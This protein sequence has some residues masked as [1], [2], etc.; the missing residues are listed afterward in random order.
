MRKF[1]HLILSGI[2]YL[3]FTPILHA[4]NGYEISFTIPELPDTGMVLAYYYSES[5][6]TKDTARSDK[7]GRFVFKGDKKLDRGVYIVVLE[8]NK[9]K[10]FDFVIDRSQNFRVETSTTNF[11]KFLKTNDPDNHLFADNLLF[12]VEM[13]KKANPFVEIINDT[14]AGESEKMEARN[15]ISAINQRVTL[16]QDSLIQVNPNALVT[17]MLK[18]RKNIEVPEPPMNSDGKIDSSF[19]YK[20]FKKH[21]WDNMDLMDDGLI[22]LP[23]PLYQNKIED[24][25]SRLV[26]PLP[27]SVNKEIDQLA[28]L[29]KSNRETYKFFI[30]TLTTKYWSPDVMGLDAVFVHLY[31]R[32]YAS[33]EMDYWA[34]GQ[35]KNNLK[36]QATRIRL[37]MIGMTAP[38]LI[39]Q[40]IA[41]KPVSMYDLKNN[42]TI[43]Y[44]Y[45]PD[46]GHCK[47]ETPVLANF[48]KNTKVD[49]QVYAVS[50]D[51]SLVKMKN[52]IKEMGLESWVN[53]NGPRTYVGH[54]QSLY[55]AMSTPTLY[56]LDEKKKIIAKKIP[57]AQ[58]DDFFRNYINSKK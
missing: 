18:A 50:V 46:C 26:L 6:Y 14:T 16:Y 40:D 58:L 53:V 52:Y 17:K 43:L 19:Q 23:F 47:T 4:Q 25:F 8:A 31:D 54:Y 39:M 33:G 7:D 32:Y 48:K 22:R 15:Q 38:N 45:D 20:Y 12:T 36:E 44:F 35:L 24:Y 1:Y 5:T 27:D 30:W 29:V 37:S 10:L 28:A 34:N 21:Y 9:T 13:N 55:D 42:Y 3:A 51:T 11:Y 41:G 2:I 57:A 56:I 49:V